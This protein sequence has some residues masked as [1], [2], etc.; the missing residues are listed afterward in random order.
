MGRGKDGVA[1]TKDRRETHVRSLPRLLACI[2]H[3]IQHIHRRVGLDRDPRA[4]A[5]L[6]DV[7]DQTLC[8]D[9]CARGAV[10]GFSRGGVA[11]KSLI[12]EAVEVCACGGEGRDPAV[13]LLER[14]G[15]ECKSG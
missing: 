11:L 9:G 2:Q 6:M 8:R 1:D 3:L 14:S 4:H 12:V 10:F 15:G 7:F 5:T 13:G